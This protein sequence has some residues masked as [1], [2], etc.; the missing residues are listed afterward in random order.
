MPG[1]HL[2]YIPLWYPHT[3]DPM[4]GLFVKKHANAAIEAGYRVSVAFA[5][6]AK[7]AGQQEKHRIK[8]S[9]TDGL[10]EVEV[11]YKGGKGITGKIRQL[12]AWQKAINKAVELG[13]KP[14][15]IHSHVLTRTAVL[16]MLYGWK[17]KVPFI[18]TEHWSRYY[19]ENRQF[20]GR[21]NKM[22]TQWVLNKAAKVTVVSHRLAMAMKSHGLDFGTDI[23]PNVVDTNLFIPHPRTASPVKKI[24]AISCFDEKAKN[25][26]MLMDAFKML[27]EENKNVQLVLIGEGNDLEMTKTQAFKLQFTPEEVIFTGMLQN[28]ALVKQLQS[29]DCLALSSNYETFGIVAFEALACGVP[30]VATDVADIALHITPE[31]GRVVPV[32][33]ASAFKNALQD[34]LDNPASFSPGLMRDFALQNYNPKA[35]SRHLDRLYKPLL[36]PRP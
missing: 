19:P 30:V 33:D 22:L 25:L 3:G 36:K 9:E 34:V 2:L 18:I 23:L 16:A 4:L 17:Y 28:E 29:A 14:E 24:V 21:I 1:P 12:R 35:I 5:V 8:T 26:F 20:K 7:E 15:L 31:M 27:R 6:A 13:G 10:L 11:T 32:N